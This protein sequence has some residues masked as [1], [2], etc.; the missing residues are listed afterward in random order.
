MTTVYETRYQ[1]STRLEYTDNVIVEKFTS[2]TA[3]HR[4]DRASGVKSSETCVPTA[5]S[6]IEGI[7]PLSAVTEYP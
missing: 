3:N 7:A 1:L 2:V 5:A 4:N 6:V